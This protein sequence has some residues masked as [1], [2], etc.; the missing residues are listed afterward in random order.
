MLR[1]SFIGLVL[2]V[3]CTKSAIA[4]SPRVVVDIAPTYSLVAQVMK[5]I[6]QPDL[7]VTSGASPH[8]YAMRPSDANALES[9]NLIFWVSRHLTPWLEN[10]MPALVQNAAIVELLNTE[11]TT[12]L[13][14]RK[15]AT[16]EGH[17]DHDD[18]GHEGHGDHD[19]EGHEDHNHEGVDPHGWL[20]PKNSIGWLYVIAE[21]LSEIDPNNAESY[22]ENADLGRIEIEKAIS[23][24][25]TLLEQ[26][27]GTRFIVFHDAYQYFE[28]YFGILAAGAISMSDATDPSPARLSKIHK[29]IEELNV[30]CVFSEPQFN[31]ALID[32]AIGSTNAKVA[33][34]DP[35]GSQLLLDADF[36]PKLLKTIGESIASCAP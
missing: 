21:K 28:D 15:G 6:G 2:G 7:L 33:I 16:F 11:N 25:E 23:E 13:A 19:D 3:L 34:I 4:D 32:S 29:T 14:Y 17:E 31:P 12:V 18:E 26:V 1:F 9:A 30:T 24:T 8:E 20:S 35:L 22:L 36:Y 10:A 5:G 27:R